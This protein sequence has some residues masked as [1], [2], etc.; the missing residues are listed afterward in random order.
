MNVLKE[1]FQTPLNPWITKTLLLSTAIGKFADYGDWLYL[2]NARTR[3]IGDFGPPLK[4][5]DNFFLQL[6]VS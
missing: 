3:R 1:I 4:I 5:L 2:H 6:L